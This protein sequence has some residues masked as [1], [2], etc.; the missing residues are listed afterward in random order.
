[1][2]HRNGHEH[3]KLQGGEIAVGGKWKSKL[4][5]F[6]FYHKWH[7]LLVLFV[8]TV[9]LVCILQS[10]ENKKDDV[11]L[12][13]A[14]PYKL[15]ATEVA[16]LRTGLN[17]VM[18]ADFNEDGEKYAE[19]VMMQIFSEAQEAEIRATPEGEVPPYLGYID[20]YYN[21]EQVTSF[22]NLV[23]AGEYSICIL[24]SWLYER[25]KG[26]GGFRKLS[27][28]LG[29]T[30]EAALDEYGVLLSDTDFAKAYPVCE[31][32]PEGTVICLRAKGV[33]NSLVNHKKSEREYADAEQMFRAIL[34]FTLQNTDADAAAE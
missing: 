12:M 27:D 25:V 13:F 21:D 31:V 9:L 30:P 22:D 32:L 16:A 14:G 19:M 17:D 28:V 20:S 6:W 2:D 10:R 33:M 24:D 8:V 11:V 26:A 18:P 7:I 4:D 5:N 3:D 29:Y 1:M 34:N 23:L 15:T